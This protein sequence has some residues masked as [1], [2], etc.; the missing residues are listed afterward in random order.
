MHEFR[1]LDPATQAAILYHVVF[2]VNDKIELFKI[3][4]T[5]QKYDSYT[6]KSKSVI[7]SNWWRS[8]AVQAG[9]IDLKYI[10]ESKLDEEV[11]KAVRERENEKMKGST[12]SKEEV[13]FLNLDEFLAF[14]NDQANKITDE[15]ERRSWVEMIGKYMNFKEND[16]ETEQIRAYTPLICSD[17]P[18]YQEAK[19]GIT[20]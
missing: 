19:K 16:E 12:R 11:K 10:L 9:I 13:N 15:K 5:P 8:D 2:Q 20:L 1:K 14:A 4:N 3:A 18:L 6:D 7:L 17:C